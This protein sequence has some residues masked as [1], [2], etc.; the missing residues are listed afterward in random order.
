MFSF[1][2]FA[3]RRKT[4]PQQ[5]RR[6]VASTHGARDRNNQLQ[7]DNQQWICLITT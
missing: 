1:I 6:Y 3:K 2:S 4:Y 7:A 5:A